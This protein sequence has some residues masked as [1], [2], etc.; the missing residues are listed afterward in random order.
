MVDEGVRD[1]GRAVTELID[2]LR[3]PEMV[4]FSGSEALGRDGFVIAT[5]VMIIGGM[6]R[7]V[8]VAHKMQQK[9]QR[10]DPFC[11]MRGRVGELGRELVDLVNDA[12]VWRSH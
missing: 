11:R 7:L 5:R 9:L 12:I 6:Q 8:Y 4:E 2:E 1:L 3:V 10:H